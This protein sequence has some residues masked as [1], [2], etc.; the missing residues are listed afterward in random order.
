[1]TDIIIRK[2][3]SIP[4]WGAFVGDKRIASVKKCRSCL[5]KVMKTVTKNSGKY[6]KIVVLG[7]DGLVEREFPTG[8][9]NVH[10]VDRH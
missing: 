8:A 7:K 6:N 4:G 10:M 3:L 9:A 2:D 5:I 1:M